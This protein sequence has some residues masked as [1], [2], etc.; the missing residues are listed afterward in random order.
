MRWWWLCCFLLLL[1][2]PLSA[3]I[4]L[5]ETET[6]DYMTYSNEGF[7]FGG[8]LRGGLH[9]NPRGEMILANPSTGPI[10][11]VKNG[12]NGMRMANEGNYSEWITG[13]ESPK[14]S[15]WWGGAYVRVAYDLP[16][17]TKAWQNVENK[18]ILP[19]AL[20][21]LGFGQWNL[22]VGRRY[23]NKISIEMMDYYV[24]NLDG[25]G[26][27]VE[28]LNL[29]FALFDAN[30]LLSYKTTDSPNAFPGKTSLAL[31]LKDWKTGPITFTFMM[32][33]SLQS[34]QPAQEGPKGGL[35]ATAKAL[36]KTPG[37]MGQVE[38]FFSGGFGSGSNQNVDTV[39]ENITPKDWSIL[40]GIQGHMLLI[41][42]LDLLYTVYFEHRSWEQNTDFLAIGIRPMIKLAPLFGVQLEYDFETAFTTK[43]MVNRFT[44]APTFTPVDGGV[45]SGVQIYPYITLA[46]GDFQGGEA[47]AFHSNKDIGMS[48]GLA[49]NIGF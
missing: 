10:W 46:I 42:R 40:G 29:G 48:F 22:W 15:P 24:A 32:V 14:D 31:V 28:N 16:D 3:E 35:F 13:Y 18:L 39:V 38:F 25:N 1:L 44:L 27:G 47:V 23:N 8:Y 4:G 43:D 19:E 33:P 7:I 17:F 41:P 30:L 49:G 21:R 26:G 36:W 34:V 2:L 12:Y 9:L 5:R 11:N 45:K 6:R 20:L 37:E